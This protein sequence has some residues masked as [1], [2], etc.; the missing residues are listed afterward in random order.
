MYSLSAPPRPLNSPEKNIRKITR[1]RGNISPQHMQTK[2]AY[3]ADII[4]LAGNQVVEVLERDKRSNEATK[5]AVWHFEN[6]QRYQLVYEGEIVLK[7]RGRRRNPETYRNAKFR[8]DMRLVVDGDQLV[9]Q[10][11]D[12]FKE[13]DLIHVYVIPV[14]TISQ[15]GNII[16]SD[17]SFVD[18]HAHIIYEDGACTYY[19]THTGQ[20]LGRQLRRKMA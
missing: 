17:K 7:W 2:S 8:S 14:T 12:T 11:I 4:R 3:V 19:R 20:Q 13:R 10:I 16:L 5:L 18:D 6:R 1:G 9:V 15:D